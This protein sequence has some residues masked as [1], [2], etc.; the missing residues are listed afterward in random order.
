MANR[1]GTT[2]QGSIAALNGAVT[3]DCLNAG[4]GA[5]QITGTYSATLSFQGSLDGTNWFSVNAVT[6]AGSA[7][8]TSTTGNGQ[9]LVGL[10]GLALFRVI[11]TVYASG[12][13]VVTLLGSIG[14]QVGNTTTAGVFGG[15]AA[16]IADGAD[17]AE[18]STTDAA[19]SVGGTGTVSAK[20]RKISADLGALLTDHA[21]ATPTAVASG[22]GDAQGV[23][24]AANLR[25]VG[26]TCRE[27]A[28][29]PAAAEFILRHGTDN[30]GTPLA[31]VKLAANE[32][33][34]DWNGPDGVAA[35]SGIFV[36]RVSGTTE[37]TI[38]SKVAA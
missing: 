33:R 34:A 29:S 10:S 16:T 22:T 8:V 19:A 17:V 12:A 37:I 30:T 36:D 27:N 25:Y 13:A 4:G 9:W 28:G 31:F 35:A 23:A 38:F 3:V 26:F 14:S 20:L 32:S 24:A 15:G 6:F 2:A 11:A 21:A 5:I 18:G 1:T 7:P